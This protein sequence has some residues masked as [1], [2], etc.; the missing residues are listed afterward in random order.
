MDVSVRPADAAETVALATVTGFYGTAIGAAGGGAVAWNGAEGQGGGTEKPDEKGDG[1]T[2]GGKPQGP[3]SPR[4]GSP[5]DQP[6]PP[7]ED[8]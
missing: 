4:P 6:P 8:E 7:Q 2:D 1:G 3:A 5:P